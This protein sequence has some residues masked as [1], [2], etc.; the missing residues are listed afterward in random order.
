MQES[1]KP[2]GYNSLSPYLMV[3]NA[4]DYLHFLRDVFGASELRR[5]NDPDGTLRHAELQIDDSIVMI[6]NS[7]SDW[8]ANKHMLH[9]YVTDAR[10]IYARAISYGCISMEAPTTQEGDPDLRG[11]FEDPAGNCWAV[12]TQ[13]HQ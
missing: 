8:P 12:G 1:Y 4:S 6:S 11:M 13:Q 3:D 7:T 10:A 9:L 2:S 5:F